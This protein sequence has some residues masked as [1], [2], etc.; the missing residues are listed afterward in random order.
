MTAPRRWVALALLAAGAATPAA[1]PVKPNRPPNGV[2]ILADD[3][4]YGHVG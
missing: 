2:L 4:G 1:E 3:L